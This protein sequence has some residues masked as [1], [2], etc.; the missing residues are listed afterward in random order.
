MI[1]QVNATNYLKDRG[2][3][4]N[5][6]VKPFKY[7][8]Q[9]SSKLGGGKAAIVGAIAGGAIGLGFAIANYISQGEDQYNVAK[10]S[11][12]NVNVHKAYK[13]YKTRSRFQRKYSRRYSVKR[14]S[15]CCH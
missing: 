13:P 10:I 9:A 2:I 7:S 4:K 6:W 1:A 11:P 12:T 3:F 5:D 15:C 8:V 14:S